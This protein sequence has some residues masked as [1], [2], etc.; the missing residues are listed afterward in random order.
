M[1]QLAQIALG[2]Y[3]VLLIAGGILGKVKSG[4]TISLVTGGLFGIAA[5]CAVWF[6]TEDPGQGLLTGA[7]LALLLTGVF[8]SRL[9]RTRKWMPT[10]VVLVLSLAVGIL[11]VIARRGLHVPM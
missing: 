2:I 3:G 5:L 10:G 11:L 8:L 4:S 1:V 6:S 7:M 9:L